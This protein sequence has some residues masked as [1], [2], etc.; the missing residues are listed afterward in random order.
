MVFVPFEILKSTW[1]FP[2]SSTAR[3]VE[4]PVTGDQVKERW[5]GQT[6]KRKL[7]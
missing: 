4:V 3:R 5:L 6:S 1:W 2:T 7:H